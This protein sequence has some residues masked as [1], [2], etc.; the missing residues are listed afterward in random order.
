MD[1]KERVLRT[2][3]REDVD[4]PAVWLGEPTSAAVRHLEEFFG[5][6][7]E[8]A[9]KERLRDDIHNFN[10]PYE[11]PTANHI[12]NAFDFAKKGI[13]GQSYEERTLTAPGF[14]EDYEDPSL[15]DDFDWPDPARYIDREELA[16]R[17]RET[18]VGKAAMVITWSAHFQDACSAF[19]METALAKMMLEPEM[20]KAVIDRIT[21]FYLTANEI[22]Y[23]S[24]KGHLDLILIGNDFGTQRNLLVSPELLRTLVFDGTKKLIDQAHSYGVSVIHHSCGSIHPIIGD[25]VE[26]GADA[27]HPIQALAADM[28]AETLKRDFGS[29][30]SFV[31]GVD[32]QHLLPHESPAN[33]EDRV[34]ELV[35]IFP[36]GLVISPSHEA[37]LADVPVENIVA[38]FRGTGVTV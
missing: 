1:S 19:G 34:R 8:L 28:S 32:A 38:M 15:V 11:S 30:A 12:A 33:V 7:G 23:E 27:I 17:A 16:R 6:N 26:M 22:V 18:P 24:T 10:V 2:I 35:E 29:I 25:L 3:R 5:L 37:L 20:F 4:R 31:G 14:F 36:T 9:I 21:E 13:D